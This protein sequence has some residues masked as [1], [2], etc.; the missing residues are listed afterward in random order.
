MAR[1]VA[2][3]AIVLGLVGAIAGSV[4][5]SYSTCTIGPTG[6]CAYPY[7]DA[8]NVMLIF[9]G[10][11]LIVG[12]VVL[13]AV[14]PSSPSN[15]PALTPVSATP[16]ASGSLTKFCPVCGAR[17]PADYNVCPRHATELKDVQ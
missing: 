5:A 6:L 1:G 9:S 14:P 15:E 17:Y 3:G 4:L 12:V 7:R 8:G 2:F 11:F 10:V 16:P 13:L